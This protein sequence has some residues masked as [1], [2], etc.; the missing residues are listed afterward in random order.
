ME[1]PPKRSFASLW[2]GGT[3]PAYRGRGLYR[4]LVAHRAAE[5][6]RGGYRFLTIDARD[7]TSRPILER[8]GAVPL[9]GTTGWRLRPQ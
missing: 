9:V 5:A 8:L 1:L 3:L 2:G 4:G 7:A 6:L